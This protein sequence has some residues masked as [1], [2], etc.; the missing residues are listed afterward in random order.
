MCPQ[1]SVYIGLRVPCAK[2]K[3][4][5]NQDNALEMRLKVSLT[6]NFEEN[7]LFL[8]LLPRLDCPLSDKHFQ[9]VIPDRLRHTRH[10]PRTGKI[11]K[12]GMLHAE[13]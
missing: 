7:L 8:P 1:V 5:N 6:L 9:M 11:N 2:V 12:R 3:F 10:I 4:Q 13:L